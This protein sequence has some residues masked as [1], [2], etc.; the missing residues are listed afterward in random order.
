MFK[1]VFK[2]FIIFNL[3]PFCMLSDQWSEDGKDKLRSD[4]T[5]F[6][7]TPLLAILSSH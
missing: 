3:D 1:Y 2:A 6:W 5:D 7:I 4:V